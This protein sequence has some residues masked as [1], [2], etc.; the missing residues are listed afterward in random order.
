MRPRYVAFSGSVMA[1]ETH[2]GG[3]NFGKGVFPLDA[4]TSHDRLV[5]HCEVLI[6]EKVCF[7]LLSTRAPLGNSLAPAARA[8]L[9]LFGNLEP[10]RAFHPNCDE[11]AKR[12][13]SKDPHS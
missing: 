4:S 6:L 11:D 9:L 5:H 2:R 13:I 8:K 12:R 1:R 10:S 7:R 3:L